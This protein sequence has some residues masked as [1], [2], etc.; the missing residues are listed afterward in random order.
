[1]YIWKWIGRVRY[2]I[3]PFLGIK[4]ADASLSSLYSFKK[5]KSGSQATLSGP[6]CYLNPIHKEIKLY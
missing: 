6:L 4:G 5:K 3:T 1:M 2:N